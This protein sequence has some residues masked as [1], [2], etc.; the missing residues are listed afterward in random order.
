MSRRE[1]APA[2]YCLLQRCQPT[3]AA[4]ERSFSML[5]KLL[6]KTETFYRRML[7]AICA[8]TIIRAIT[9]TILLLFSM[10]CSYFSFCAVLIKLLFCKNKVTFSSFLGHKK[11]PNLL[12]K[13]STGVPQGSVL[14]PL[15]FLI[16]IVHRNCLLMIAYLSF[17]F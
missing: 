14:R 17:L 1:V 8:C 11:S 9:E 13:V 10:D 6:A 16:Y 7:S 15:F 4:V 3:T 12:K 2:V 5:N